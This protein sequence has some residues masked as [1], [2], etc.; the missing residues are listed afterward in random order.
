[1]WKSYEEIR[2]HPADFRVK[3]RFYS[4]EEGGR[5]K[6]VLQGYRSDFCYDGDDIRDGIYCIHPEFE[7]DQGNVNLSDTTPVPIEGTAR[8]W[9]LFPEM[10]KK[11]HVDRIRIGVIG[12]F[13]EGPKK[14]A[15]AEVIEI[16]G[17]RTNAE[18]LS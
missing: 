8:M 17:L 14:V 10:R 12:Y 5:K 1:M 16:L 6:P 3:Y 13:M 7:D 9:I 4:Q 18:L 2:K 11:I 15:K